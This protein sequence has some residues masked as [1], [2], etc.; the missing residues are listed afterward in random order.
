MALNKDATISLKP[1]ERKRATEGGQPGT[2]KEE[3][4]LRTSLGRDPKTDDETGDGEDRV[5]SGA[6]GDGT[7]FIRNVPFS[8]EEEDLL[9]ILSNFGSLHYCKIVRDVQTGAAKGTAFAKFRQPKAAA[10][11]I[12]ASA[13]LTQTQLEA[14]QA[15]M[16]TLKC[17]GS[18]VL[19]SSLASVEDKLA[20]LKKKRT[21]KEFKSI[22]DE[23]TLFVDD[24][25]AEEGIVIDGRALSIVSA[26]DRKT[27]ATLKKDGGFLDAGPQDR[28]NLYLLQETL[29]KPKTE[30]ARHFWPT[31]DIGHRQSLVKERRTQLKANSNLF[32]SKTRLSL[33]YLPTGLDEADVRLVMKTALQ[34][35]LA[36][37][38]H[39]VGAAPILDP[40][41]HTLPAP[42]TASSES[43][44]RKRRGPVKQI[45][46]V[47]ATGDREGRSKGFGFV[48]YHD[49][50]HALLL[51]RFLN[52]YEPAIWKELLP[53]KFA[54]KRHLV[55]KRGGAGDFVAKAPVVEFATENM[56]VVNK[57]DKFPDF[58]VKK[59]L[60]AAAANKSSRS[61]KGGNADRKKPIRG[62]KKPY[63]RSSNRSK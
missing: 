39:S 15:A 58:E 11:A 50:L 41:H 45:K 57:R 22:L 2:G 25:A 6:E 17:S 13:R 60:A 9:E 19:E 14:N 1:S 36:Y 18:G 8:T 32:I 10:E 54:G 37:D 62:E 30:T 12:A 27:A 44:P 52:N 31:L 40:K 29:L 49:H 33:R 61:S 35:A 46:I 5:L 3:K 23:A 34:R 4:K 43:A 28:R 20:E 21:G 7:V 38:H 55:G 48:E 59:S 47:R 53:D 56:T 42:P 63:N 51:V 26:V 24:K 16:D